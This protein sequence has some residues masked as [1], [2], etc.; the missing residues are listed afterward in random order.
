MKHIK[1][2]ENFAGSRKILITLSSSNS[3]NIPSTGPRTYPGGYRDPN[4]GSS[5]S[6]GYP[7]K[8]DITELC[9]EIGE[10]TNEE[11]TKIVAGL[12]DLIKFRRDYEGFLDESILNNR[13]LTQKGLLAKRKLDSLLNHHPMCDIESQLPIE[14]KFRKLNIDNKIVFYNDFIDMEFLV[15]RGSYIYKVIDENEFDSLCN[16]ITF[17]LETLEE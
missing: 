2:F 7:E 17:R 5:W 3:G 10:K 8:F 15:V 12:I 9:Q 6:I 16:E 1:L 14:K 13:R 11:Y 4:E